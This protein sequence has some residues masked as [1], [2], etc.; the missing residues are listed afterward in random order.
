[1]RN[2]N[3]L[4]AP[5]ALLWLSLLVGTAWAACPPPHAPAQVVQRQSVAGPSGAVEVRAGMG[6]R[7]Q[8]RLVLLDAACHE[9]LS[10]PFGGQDVGDSGTQLRFRVETIH[11]FPT[12][13]IIGTLAT[14]GGSDTAFETE[15]IGPVH[16]RFR[17]LLPKP[18]ETLLEGG[19]FVGDLGG[20]LG[21]GIAI[22]RMIWG[23]N[24]AHVSPHRYE[25]QRMR[26]TGTSF[27]SVATRRTK[28]KYTSPAPALQE[29]GVNYTDL[30]RQFADFERYR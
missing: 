21:P 25:L 14:Q 29:L 27:H 7:T 28:R 24:E 2:A 4:L 20:K 8:P 5:A 23:A 26:W 6:A 10:V 12:P 18:A 22:W 13:L 9:V 15:L 3:R 11:G 17:K 19:V 16:G 1:M 30:T